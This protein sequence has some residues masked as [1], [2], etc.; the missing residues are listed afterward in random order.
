MTRLFEWLGALVLFLLIIEW[1]RE[2]DD[3]VMF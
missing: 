1:A 3:E 2:N